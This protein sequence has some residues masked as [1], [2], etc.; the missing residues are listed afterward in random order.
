MFLVLAGPLLAQMPDWSFFR[1]RE[2]NTYYYTSSGRIVITGQVEQ[3]RFVVSAEGIDY[4]LS[5]ARRLAGE[6]RPAD[7]LA[8]CRGILA[9]EETDMRI[10]DAAAEASRLVRQLRLRH[11]DRFSN[12]SYRASLYLYR[13]DNL[14]VITD[15]E[16]R[17]SL[18][19]PL[20]PRILSVSDRRGQRYAHRGFRMGL[21]LPGSKP[22][23]E[24]F[25]ILLAMDAERFA[26]PLR[27]VDQLINQWKLR[28]GNNTWKKEVL[29]RNEYD[30][31]VRYTIP[32]E[33]T[34][35]L[36][37]YHIMGRYGYCVRLLTTNDTWN[38]RSDEIQKILTS[39]SFIRETVEQGGLSADVPV[40]A[41]AAVLPYLFRQ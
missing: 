5:L 1:D 9:L 19:L 6:G 10:R 41:L 2:G 26:G 25:D 36:E 33:G 30:V 39:W 27:H 40:P 38:G 14:T 21:D 32:G 28:R 12:I 22:G 4:Y 37:R 20:E 15:E 35:G 8:I 3:K 34:T 29:S 31:L 24:G 23:R 7:A 17:H 18:G 11:G 13:K 16:F